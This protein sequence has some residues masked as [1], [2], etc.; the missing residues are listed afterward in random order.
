M[1]EYTGENGAAKDIRVF[2]QQSIISVEMH[3]W[4]DNPPFLKK[5]LGINCK[6]D[7]INVT[8]TTLLTGLVYFF[9]TMKVLSGSLGVG[10][11]VRYSGLVIQFIL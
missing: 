11:L 10:S 9:V 6:Y 1:D 4:F 5:R 3:R 8:I 2:E 7:A